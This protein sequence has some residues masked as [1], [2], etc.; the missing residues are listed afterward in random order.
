MRKQAVAN[1][2][3]FSLSLLEALMPKVRSA[4]LTTWAGAA[5]RE[6]RQQVTIPDTWLLCS[7]EHDIEVVREDETLGD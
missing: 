7:G 4:D 5:N 6:T 2:S 3:S 1:M